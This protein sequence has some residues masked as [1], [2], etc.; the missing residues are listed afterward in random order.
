MI[1]IVKRLC[2]TIRPSCLALALCLFAPGLLHAAPAS[3]IFILHSYSQEYAWTRGQHEGFIQ[4]LIGWLRDAYIIEGVLGGSVTSGQKQGMSAA[5]LL[6]AYQHGKP[7]ADLPPIL[8]SPNALIFDDRVLE[9]HGIDLPESLRSQAV[10]LHPRP[11][12]YERYRLLILGMLVGLAALLFLVVSVSLMIL[13]RKNRELSLAQNTAESANALFNQ[14]AEQSRTVHWEVNAEGVYTHVS[15]VSSAVLGYRPDELVDR[16]H[17]YDLLCDGEQDVKKTAVFEC[18]VRKEPFH[19]LESAIQTRDGRRIWVST[20]GFPLL[21]GSG[22][23]LG[24][25]G[26]DSDI[27]ARK[28]AEEAL[29]TLSARQ[30]AILDTVPEILIEV[31]SNKVYTWANKPGMDF[32]GEE[33]IGKEAA[34]YFEGEQE[35]YRIVQPL[36][37]G[38]EDVI[39]LESYQ[40]RRDGGKRL[41]AWYC[42]VR[43]DHNGQVTGALSSAR[44][45]TE[46]KQAEKQLEETLEGLRKAVG[47]TIQVLASAVETRDPYTAGHQI[48]SADLARAIATEM[49]LPQNQIDG[50]RMA[51]S[52]HD[53]GKLSVPAEILSKPT[54]LSELE[55]SL[56][57]EHAVK[58]FEMLKDVQSPWPLAEIVY[59]HHERMDGSGYPRRLKGEEILMEARILVVADVVESMASHRPYRPARGI[60]AALDEIL[61]NSG[62]LY[63][64]AVADACRRLFLEKGFHL[65]S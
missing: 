17:F 13:S 62:I 33:V 44:D 40:R 39:Y 28:R 42:R 47:A 7:I 27:T 38:S 48:R 9:Q 15:P 64:A 55:F 63:D 51:G 61:K 50:I 11:G 3:P 25:R 36:F 35:T 6:L 60:E 46:R 1:P 20:N 16:K 56:I 34:F 65:S 32:F 4:P 24:Y 31:D 52:I 41:L 18:F 10:L 37:Q 14:L 22:A 49:G 19:D 26:S 21:D 2:S 8:K 12:F 30:E 57:K 53:I 45:I 58:G 43:K 5:R 29:R 23:F 54:E 59:Q